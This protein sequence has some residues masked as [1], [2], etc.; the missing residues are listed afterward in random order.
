MRDNVHRINDGF[1][2]INKIGASDIYRKFKVQFNALF[3]PKEIA[4]S[5]EEFEKIYVHDND[6][7]KDIEDFRKSVGSM[8]AFCVGYTGIGKTTSL[9]Y[10]FDLGIKN[11]TVY[12]EKR[13]ELV[14]P[15]FFDGHNNLE[16]DFSD[17]LAKK[18]GSVCSY[19]E[20]NNPDLKRHMKTK[21]G[22]SEL[23]AFIEETKPE[24]VEVDPLKLV[25]MS[26]IQEI[27]YK[28]NYAY[29]NHKYSYNAIRL[30]FMIAK[31]YDKYERLII[32]LDDVESLPEEE[33]KNLIRL[34]LSFFDCMA[35]TEFPENSEYNINLLISLRP[36]T[37][38]LF[39]SNS[40]IEAYPILG[41][42]ITKDK[43]ADL[44]ELF[45]KRFDYYTERNPRVIG[46]IDSWNDCYDH[47]KEI[48]EM[49]QGQYK[50]MIINLCDMNIREA[51]S[52]YARIFANRLW[53]QRNKEVYAE[54]TISIP[55]Y[56]FNSITIIRALA[57]NESR[58]YFNDAN[59][60]LPCIFLNDMYKDYTVYCLLLLNLFYNRKPKN[61]YY[62]ETS[63]EKKK[64]ISELEEIFSS[65]IV[66]KFEECLLHLFTIKLLKKSIR[67]KDDYEVLDK[68]DSLKDNSLL[69]L[70]SKGEEMWKMFAQDSVLLEM[71]REAVYRDCDKVD[72]NMQCSLELIEN[73]RQK[74]I[75]IDLL[76]YIEYLSYMED[77]LRNSITE[78]AKREKYKKMFGNEMIVLHLLE[79][80]KCSLMYSGK[81]EEQDIKLYF[82]N[83]QKLLDV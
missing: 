48:N 60:L 38:R 29:N 28:L 49:F 2:Q 59:N 18:I 3:N 61:E 10:C 30:K 80:V 54:F 57:C 76:K 23:I 24:I 25:N 47:L 75:F 64:I 82:L 35:N 72:F 70:S 65:E 45:Q 7:E 83:L 13:K 50:T 8:A 51:L 43:P 11:V 1:E 9:R 40:N 73:G 34:Y 6:F 66:Q 5:K 63:Q 32:I 78:G 12:N 14:F 81:W 31:E 41:Y 21:A 53:V 26:E 17:A 36:D 56:T 27:H 20:R 69:Y 58:V 67:D 55:E 37:Y 42:P 74:E 4:K 46:N 33:Q 71:L 44:T 52:C 22:L 68:K 62:G 79:G 39:N 77:D 19:L 16:T 15:S